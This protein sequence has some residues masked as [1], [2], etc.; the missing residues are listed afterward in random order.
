MSVNPTLFAPPVVIYR[1]IQSVHHLLWIPGPLFLN[2]SID[3]NW[4]EISGQTFCNFILSAYEEVVHWSSNIFWF[5]LGRLEEAFV[6]ELT[7][8]YQAFVDDSALHSIA[9][10]GIDGLF[11]YAASVIAKTKSEKQG[12][13]SF[14]PPH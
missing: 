13:E 1:T 7:R 14:S 12:Q 8:L 4:G 9:M 11:C 10:M 6:P 2:P 5:H 3:F